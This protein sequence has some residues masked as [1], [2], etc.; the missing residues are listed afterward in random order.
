MDLVN[1][2]LFGAVL[3]PVLDLVGNPDATA[4]LL[5]GLAFDPAPSR[6]FPDG[7]GQHVELL[8]QFVKTHQISRK[9]VRRHS[10]F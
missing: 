8:D 1:D 7:C 2:L 4:N 6:R 3:Q 5:I 9:S 10:K